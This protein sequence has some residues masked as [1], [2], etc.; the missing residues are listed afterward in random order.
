MNK[1]VIKIGSLVLTKLNGQLNKKVI[2]NIVCDVAK[3]I[4]N[5]KKKVVII[6]SGAVSSG[7]V[8]D[9]FKTNFF[10]RAENQ[11]KKI[12]RQQILASIGQPR[13]MSFYAKEFE[14]HGLI[15]A[16]I[17]VTRADFSNRERYLSLRGVVEN[18]LNLNIIPVI[19]ENDVLLDEDLTFGDNDQLACMTAAMLAASKLIVLTNVE[20]VY[21]RDPKDRKAKILTQINNVE[22]IILNISRKKNEV[23]RGGMQSKLYAAQLITSL[24]IPMHI[25]SG[26]R[27]NI[28]SDIVLKDKLLGTFFTVKG[29]QKKPF[30]NWIATSSIVSGSIIINDCL[31]DVL[32]HKK[33]ASVLLVG[34]INALGRFKKGDIINICDSNN[35]I[36]GKGQSRY[37][38]SQLKKEL[39]NNKKILKVSGGEKIV[40]HYDYLVLKK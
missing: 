4:K 37:S 22:D 9:K 29:K 8:I 10:V 33:F 25:A 36:L 27:S 3:I 17:L 15:C 7:K 12:V 28:T 1:I 39:K 38:A 14:R 6:S 2:K 18:L 24:G 26:F 30:K 19:N 13:L 16:Q 34:I 21:D 11:N 20:G 31:A 5:G 23:G 32:R 35:N 40:I